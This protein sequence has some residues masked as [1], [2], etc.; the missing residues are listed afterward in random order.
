VLDLS[1]EVTAA[2]LA[3]R[4]GGRG[5]SSSSYLSYLDAGAGSLL[6]LQSV[7]NVTGTRELCAPWLWRD[8]R[9]NYTKML[10]WQ[11]LMST[12]TLPACS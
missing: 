1:K 10:S 3:G 2:G 4:E 12:D 6:F 9:G 7:G 11:F 5:R 8:V